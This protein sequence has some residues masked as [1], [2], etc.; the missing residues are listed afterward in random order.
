MTASYIQGGVRDPSVVEFYRYPPAQREGTRHWYAR[1]QNAVVEWVESDREQA[2][3][4]SAGIDETLVLVP[5]SAGS[6]HWESRDFS[7]PAAAC[8]VVPA[9]PFRITLEQPGI[10][11]CLY[12]R[13]IRDLVSLSINHEAYA[14]RDKRIT[15]VVP[16]QRIRRP[17]EVAVLPMGDA[18]IIDHSRQTRMFQSATV[19]VSWTEYHG[20]RNPRHLSPHTHSDFEQASL[21]V[22]GK[23]THHMRTPWG[24]DSRQW[25]P[26]RHEITGP[27]SLAVFPVGLVHTV[28]GIGPGSHALVDIFSPPRSDY[29]ER[30]YVS[31][32]DDYQVA[33]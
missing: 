10:C 33:D 19:S 29:I 4:T 28:A 27:G 21:V 6:V 1:T 22:R 2:S 26:D 24:R 3:F 18:P 11:I 7:F 32:A 30:G 31:N 5:D 17:G 20:P 9:G 13:P 25:R 14:S 16:M 8:C 12:S 23:F 15:R